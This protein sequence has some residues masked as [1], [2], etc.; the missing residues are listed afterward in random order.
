MGRSRL[1][2]DSAAVGLRFKFRKRGGYWC[3]RNGETLGIVENTRNGWAW[4]FDGSDRRW[5]GFGSRREAAADL[6]RAYY[7]RG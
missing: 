5:A 3:S 4:H 6:A 7:A 1:V 2:F